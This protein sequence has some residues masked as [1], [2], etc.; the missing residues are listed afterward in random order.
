MKY[1]IVVERKKVKAIRISIKEGVAHVSCPYFVSDSYLKKV[2]DDKRDWIIETINKQINDSKVYIGEF[3][4]YRGKKY[5]LT[6][7]E[8]NRAVRV[9]K[10]ELIIYCRNNN[11]EKALYECGK[12]EIMRVVEER[13]DKYLGI[14]RDYGYNQT[15]EYH[16]SHLTSKWG[17]CYCNR[18]EIR[19]SDRLIHFDDE[20]IEAVLWHEL[21]HL[22]IPH[23]SKRFHAVL[24]LH[25]RDYER[26]IK[27][28]R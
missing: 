4:Y 13:Q 23:H 17:V 2:I 1:Q 10:D 20:H 16:I 15:P 14:L 3:I 28:I 9:L 25:M 26:L 27:E 6:V 21:L 12:K 11:Y 24:N 18:N 5:R 19:L 22:V 8:G 7:K